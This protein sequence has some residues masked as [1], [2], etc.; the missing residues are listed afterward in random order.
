MRCLDEGSAARIGDSFGYA[1][2]LAGVVMIASKVERV[3][4]RA[5]LVRIFRETICGTTT[6]KVKE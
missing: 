1:A 4:F 2:W 6:F 3:L 5:M